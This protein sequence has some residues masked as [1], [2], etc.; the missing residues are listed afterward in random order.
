[1]ER[2]EAIGLLLSGPEGVSAWNRYRATGEPTPDLSGT[3]FSGARFTEIDFSDVNLSEVGFTEAHLTFANLSRANLS[4]ANLTDANF[5]RANLSDANL[6]EAEIRR[7]NFSWADLRR[8]RFENAVLIGTFLN[9]TELTDANFSEAICG[10]VVF[11]AL[12]LKSAK[13]LDKITHVQPSILGIETIARSEGQIPESFLRG[14]GLAPWEVLSAR[15]YDPSLNPPQ[16]V[17]LQYR[18]FDAW[19]R[20]KSMITGCFF[21]YSWNDS[22][23]VEKLRDRLVAE[24]I[25][26]WI[27]KYNILAGGMQDQVWRAIQTHHVM[28]LVLSEH[29]I[30]SDWVEN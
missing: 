12:D 23:F 21:S 5:R 1:M 28:I 6:K 4:S 22:Q 26:V 25:D 17:D 11:S 8:A 18:I 29:S 30:A 10:L 2:D 24:G 14:C 3:D 27:D 9:G 16:F 15:R 7:T 20:G 19:T 13:G